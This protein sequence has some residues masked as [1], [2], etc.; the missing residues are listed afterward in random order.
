VVSALDHEHR[1]L[2]TVAVQVAE[3]HNADLQRAD[4]QW[5]TVHLTSLLT[6]P[7]CSGSLQ[8]MAHSHF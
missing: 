5:F 3:H 8:T 1:I 7:E 2:L 6:T 4:Y